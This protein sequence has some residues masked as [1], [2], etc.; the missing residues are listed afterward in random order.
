MD[1][2][3]PSSGQQ[4]PQTEQ[5]LDDSNTE[6]NHA[7]TCF[8]GKNQGDGE[9]IAENLQTMSYSIDSENPNA[10]KMLTNNQRKQFVN[11]FE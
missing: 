7:I 1:S 6:L 2:S 5:K 9:K 3:F 4:K 11:M 8:E 10:A